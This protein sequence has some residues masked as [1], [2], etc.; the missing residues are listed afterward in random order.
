[1]LGGNL[2]FPIARLFSSSLIWLLP[3]PFRPF[4]L[5]PSDFPLASLALTSMIG[6]KPK[7]L[8]TSTAQVVLP[9]P[10]GPESRTAFFCKG[11]ERQGNG[12]PVES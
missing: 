3:L 11:G 10:G 5:S 6:P 4:F 12:G 7:D 8:A 2:T 1:M 9:A